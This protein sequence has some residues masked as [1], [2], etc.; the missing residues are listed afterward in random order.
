MSEIEKLKLEN[1]IL[2]RKLEIA[3]IWM[4]KEVKN[5]IKNVG[6]W[7]ID[8]KID[9]KIHNFFWDI[10][11]LNIPETVINNI[12]LAEISYCNLK[13][14]KYTDWL[15]VIFSYHKALDTIIESF[16]TKWFRRFAKKDKTLH[17]EKN[18]LLEK[19]LHSVVG[20]WYI[21]SIWRLFHILK[22]KKNNWK[23]F[24]YWNCFLKYL[25]EYKY[26]KDVLLETSFYDKLEKIIKSEV[27]WKKRH[28]WNI[29]FEETKI[30]RNILI[31]KL[32]NRDCII[33]K[34]IESQSVEF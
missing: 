13:E 19:S 30:A 20:S 1:K 17:L 21:L 6:K 23:I 29:S 31:W 24:N 9:K 14:N 12:I 3:S 25:D 7:N 16:I 10:M 11:L 5:Q 15:S 4:K 2:K 22:L 18:D 27:L 28:S 8:K 34:L 26:L 32:E 33:Y